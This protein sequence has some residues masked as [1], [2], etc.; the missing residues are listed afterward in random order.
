M[1]VDRL[2]IILITGDSHIRY[3]SNYLMS[4]VGPLPTS[5]P[6]WQPH[7]TCNNVD[8]WWTNYTYNAIPNLNELNKTMRI[9][10]SNDTG[11]TG[12]NKTDIN[13]QKKATKSDVIII[14]AGIWDIAHF[15][16]ESYMKN[17]A[18]TLLKS[19]KALLSDPFYADANI[20]LINN[21]AYPRNKHTLYRKVGFRNN[22]VLAATNYWLDHVTKPLGIRVLDA[23]SVVN[24]R[25]EEEVCGN[26]YICYQR[27]AGHPYINAT[28]GLT[29]GDIVISNICNF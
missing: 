9:F 7:F 22:H 3:L 18:S 16:P 24:I 1:F 25:Q 17:M 4:K 29:V 6:K 10:Y 5:V 19:I 2:K 13:T 12:G 26:H 8:F 15:G 20:F 14:S 21:I 11:N 23:F 28:V 27:G